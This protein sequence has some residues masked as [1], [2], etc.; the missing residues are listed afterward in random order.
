MHSSILKLVSLLIAKNTSWVN[1]HSWKCLEEVEY[2]YLT[3]KSVMVISDTDPMRIVS[4]HKP[5]YLTNITLSHWPISLPH[6][7]ERCDVVIVRQ[8]LG[9]R[10]SFELH[11][12]VILVTESLDRLTTLWQK[13]KIVDLVV[14]LQKSSECYLYIWF[15]YKPENCYGVPKLE[16]VDIWRGGKFLYNFN[17]SIERIPTRFSGCP[18]IAALQPCTPVV[19]DGPGEAKTGPE[20][21]ILSDLARHLNLTIV[22]HHPENFHGYYR[23]LA[24]NGSYSG[25]LKLL[26]QRKIDVAASCMSLGMEKAEFDYLLSHLQDYVTWLLPGPQP[27]SLAF[28]FITALSWQ[29]WVAL[30][31]TFLSFFLFAYFS[32]HSFGFSLS[33]ATAHI[34]SLPSSLS[35][36]SG[37]TFRL[38]SFSLE[39]CVLS[40]V[41]VYNS[42]LLINLFITPMLRFSSALEGAEYGLLAC[43]RPSDNARVKSSEIWEKIKD[44]RK[45]MFLDYQNDGLKKCYD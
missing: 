32:V 18:I 43:I 10:T 23:Y 16:L 38:L 7:Q 2:K 45:H 40:L 15:P 44:P 4:G 36:G 39:F 11:G 9:N 34:L 30:A 29:I 31:V 35:L 28:G 24:P 6:K 33:W 13:F 42:L 8:T 25:A 20:V 22:Q 14:I 27:K 1:E 12:R 37:T 19:L 21:E 26:I 3:A 5:I 41:S 17:L